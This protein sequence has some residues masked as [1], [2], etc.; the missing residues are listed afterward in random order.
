M[1]GPSS[2]TSSG[3]PRPR[4][5]GPRRRSSD[6]VPS[7]PTA[8]AL[9]ALTDRIEQALA[10]LRESAPTTDAGGPSDDLRQ[11]LRAAQAEL[12]ELRAVLE[13]RER[14]L[15]AAQAELAARERAAGRLAEEMDARDA[16]FTVLDERANELTRRLDASETEKGRSERQLAQV[17]GSAA[18][19]WGLA[20]AAVQ[21]G[22]RRLA[23]RLR[24]GKANPLFDFSWYLDRNPDVRW[25]GADPY[26]HYLNVGRAE[27]RTPNRIFQPG[28]YLETNPDVVASGIEPLEHYLKFG[29]A[30][31]RDPAPG[32]DLAAYLAQHPEAAD[33][34]RHPLL[35]C[36]AATRSGDPLPAGVVRILVVAWHCPTRAHAGG[37]RMLDLY[38]YLRRASPG[39]RL[40]LFA[41][42][43][44][45]ND[46]SYDDLHDIFDHVYLTDEEDLSA[47]ALNALRQDRIAYDVVDFQF[48][49]AAHDLA[50]YRTIGRKLIFT[51]MELLSR[52]YHIE[53]QKPGRV[54]SAKRFARQMEAAGREL[55]I[56]RAVD[57]VVCVSG[58][59]AAYLRAAA[60]Q[61]SVTVL[62][63]GVSAL[64]FG[65]V[66]PATDESRASKT[67]VFV[68]YFG[69]A[70]NTE[71]LDWYLA[72]VHPRI[73]AAVP[74]YRLDVVGR[75]DLGRYKARADSS[76]NLVGEVPS[77]G[78]FIARAALGVAPA[79]SGA[80]FR[81]KINQYAMLGVATVA[82][83]LAAEG[84]A[85]RDGVDILVG[86]DAVGFAEAC[87]RLLTDPDANRRMA[88]AASA[89]CAAHYAWSAR[90]ALI[91]SIYGLKPAFSADA[92]TVT[93]IVPSYNHAG[94]IEQRIR[95]ILEQNHPNI[96]LVVI[97]DAST[98]G[99]DAVIRRLRDQY[100][101]TYIRRE[102]NSG[103]PFSAWAYAA[104]T[105]GGDF[106]WICE[107]DDFAAPDFAATA[108]ERL[109]QDPSAALYYC[110]SH[111]VNEEG[112]I[113]GSTAD[114]FR[115]TWRE[116][117]WE[118]S[119]AADGK[120]ELRDFQTRGMIVPNMSS[121]LIR[122][123]A[124]RAAWN[125]DLMAFRLTGDWLF[126]GRVLR[127]GRAIFDV[128]PRSHFR[129]H[130]DTARE[131]VN[132]AR[133]QAEF[134]ITKYRLHRLAGK[135][136]RDLAVTLKAD[137]TRFIYEP[138]SAWQVLRAMAGVSLSDTVRLG[139][140]LGWSMLFHRGYWAKF[141]QRTRDR[142][143]ASMTAE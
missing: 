131:R 26:T 115:D 41:V 65:A 63:T 72:E 91:R 109:A 102:R 14:D 67:V 20:V 88:E 27:G 4:R 82:S 10:Q 133:S 73:R 78:P 1:P 2:R 99:S 48:Q 50:A 113:V 57:E 125:A 11:A 34:K 33:G 52:S 24:R 16:T 39:I 123:A 32:F 9:A 87:I 136:A 80:G 94:Y 140:G 49:D 98:D 96:E 8:L 66:A 121:A 139:A 51:P 70:T 15:Q 18:Y 60:G 107:S 5:F 35:H 13:S 47:K 46:W 19:S 135:R 53:L 44:P 68:A 118:R 114:Y 105:A 71:A 61:A 95:S 38:D 85:Y 116:P 23:R 86:A 45:K 12:A 90:D 129:K 74:D 81:G 138:A 25:T 69:S 31:G 29:A 112:R 55:A 126:I 64:E 77:I 3:I 36:L 89:T 120:A 104:E 93:A 143:Q 28:W 119:F 141:R 21:R 30:E 76:V 6:A 130:A 100:G 110:N 108:V 56:C 106:I 40:D 22:C 92:P 83:P 128:Q 111:V 62:E 101:F 142:R 58:P 137:A 59:D 122:R 127:H 117:R 42:R 132:S 124:F 17:S 75:G 54:G 79:L 7:E 84:L 37:L 134:V 43:R 97:D 103:T